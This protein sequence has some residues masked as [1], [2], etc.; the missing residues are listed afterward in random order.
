MSNGI[1]IE[2]PFIEGLECVLSTLKQYGIKY[3]L[4]IRYKKRNTFPIL[5]HFYINYDEKCNLLFTF[6]SSQ[7]N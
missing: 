2:F 3:H 4:Y 6:R 5:P 1:S 7:V